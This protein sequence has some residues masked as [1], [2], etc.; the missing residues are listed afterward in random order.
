MQ[1]PHRAERTQRASRRVFL[2]SGAALGLGAAASTLA[3]STERSELPA[4]RPADTQTTLFN[5]VSAR[6]RE[7]Y[8]FPYKEQIINGHRIH[9]VDEGTGPVV[10]LVHGQGNWSYHFRGVIQRLKGRARIICHDHLGAGLSEKPAFHRAYTIENHIAVLYG[11][12]AALELRG[13]TIYC[14][15]W[16]G[17]ISMAYATAHPDN[18]RGLVIGNTWAWSD[19][20]EFLRSPR[21]V[22]RLSP[23]VRPLAARM[24]FT[25]G[26]AVPQGDL[27]GDWSTPEA[28]EVAAY[29]ARYTTLTETRGAAFNRSTQRS[30]DHPL[31]YLRRTART[32]EQI[33]QGLPKLQHLP[34]RIVAPDDQVF[35]PAHQERWRT[36]F[37]KAPPVI[38]I[39]V[40]QHVAQGSE[41]GS[42]AIAAAIAA[43]LDE[44][45]GPGRQGGA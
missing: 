34:V 42:D 17:P 23:I 10:M 29:E 24:T 1:P 26:G 30:A 3:C 38:P 43:V 35:P 15:D 21:W 19:P 37:P 28:R 16:G 7:I 18:I 12:I 39:K 2:Q 40:A 45:A 33:E 20:V 41:V 36:I 31:E 5:G 9:Y 25:A 8:P 4:D 44:A 27:G 32:F 14:M 22:T 13:I 11:L 6:S